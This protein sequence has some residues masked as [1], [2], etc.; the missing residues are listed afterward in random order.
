M[1]L[2]EPILNL[3][4]ELVGKRQGE[5]VVVL[6]EGPQ[7]TAAAVRAVP[8]QRHNGK[9]VLEGQQAWWRPPR[10]RRSRAR[11][12]ELKKLHHVFTAAIEKAH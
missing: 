4:E 2:S 3:A 1:Q 11:G 12:Q 8:V 7:V 6:Q 9:N 10:G 5:G